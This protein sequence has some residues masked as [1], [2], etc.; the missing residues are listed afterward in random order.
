MAESR[1]LSSLELGKN[2]WYEVDL[3]R[4]S[5]DPGKFPAGEQTL[6]DEDGLRLALVRYSTFDS[7]DG[8]TISEWYISVENDTDNDI[9]LDMTEISEN[10][11]PV[12]EP[13]D[14]EAK[15]IMGLT[16]VGAHQKRMTSVQ[17]LESGITTIDFKLVIK[18]FNGNTIIDTSSESISLQA[19]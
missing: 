5:D 7:S 2:L 12:H 8:K 19:E 6:Y 17:S 9:S 11:G 15:S 18:N 10:G 13:G 3:D 14:A 4:K 16:R 1:Y